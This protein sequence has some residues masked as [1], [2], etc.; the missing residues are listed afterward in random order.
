MKN[1]KIDKRKNEKRGK[2]MGNRKK[3]NEKE[4]K[5]QIID[6]MWVYLILFWLL[7]VL[8]PCDPED[9]GPVR[10]H[11]LWLSESPGDGS[12]AILLKGRTKT[13][14]PSTPNTYK[15]TKYSFKRSSKKRTKYT[16]IQSI[17]WGFVGINFG[18]LL[19]MFGICSIWGI[20]FDE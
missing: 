17:I 1:T 7:T 13:D 5:T 10:F 12:S 9:P 4:S 11:A 3:G 19:E 6:W 8:S 16:H 14:S 2:E 15:T 20:N 18:V